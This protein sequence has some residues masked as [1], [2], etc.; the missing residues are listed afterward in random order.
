M[1]Q[2]RGLTTHPAMNPHTDTTASILLVEDNADE[3]ELTRMALS[4]YGHR[5]GVQH[6]ADG[7][8][9]LDYLFRRGRYAGRTGGD[10]RVVLLDLKMPVLDG[11]AVLR[12]VK[13]SPRMRHLPIVM[14]TSST[15]V[16]DVRA[17]YAAG[18]NAYLAK[19]TDFAEFLKSIKAL[20]EFW[21]HANQPALPTAH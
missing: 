8:Q 6:V 14:L 10:P 3:A 13:S 15:E 2:N 20:C 19:P 7:Q 9:A 21:L 17:A 16:A 12:E 1:P 5:E 18:T 4:R 11:L